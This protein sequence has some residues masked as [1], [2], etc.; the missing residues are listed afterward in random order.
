MIVDRA[1]RVAALWSWLPAFRA[2]AETEH[3]PTASQE[4]RVAASSLSRTVRL[5]EEEIGQPLFERSG[6][7][8]HLNDAGRVLSTVVRDAMRMVH[9]GL[10]AVE[11]GGHRGPVHVSVPGPL[12]PLYV[13]P[14]LDRL[15]AEHP[16]LVVH[17]H[18]TTGADANAALRRG[19]L[20][21][22][23]VDDA[24]AA[25]DLT[26]MRLRPVEHDVFVAPGHRAP[27]EALSFVA[28][29]P[30]ARGQTPDAWPLDRPRRVGLRVAQMQVA[31][32]AVRTGRYA[33]VLPV[34]VGRR[35]G[36]EGLGRSEAMGTSVLHLVH[37][38]SLPIRGRTEVV[39]D[40]LVDLVNATP[41]ATK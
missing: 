30:D 40:A 22:A 28:P 36:L 39:R 11:G 20:D 12:A 23:I 41:A 5:L 27:L 9:E 8:L 3:L 37:R 14:L 21:L 35:Q 32:E 15:A 34:V 26:F 17:V 4:L 33:A 1:R 10:L 18:A 13:L 24:V 7:R 25:E 31:I 29:L 38:P 6:R 2:V 16:H 19:D